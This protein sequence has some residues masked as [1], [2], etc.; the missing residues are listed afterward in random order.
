MKVPL[1][2]NQHNQI[3]SKFGTFQHIYTRTDKDY[4]AQL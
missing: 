2:P 3:Q 4:Y 1:N